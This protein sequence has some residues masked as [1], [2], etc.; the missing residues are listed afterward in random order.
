MIRPNENPLAMG[1]I[2]SW[3]PEVRWVRRRDLRDADD[4]VAEEGIHSSSPS[5]PSSKL[6]ESVSLPD[7]SY[8]SL[9]SELNR[10]KEQLMPAATACAD[11]INTY[12]QSSNSTNPRYEFRKARSSCNP[13]ESLG[14]ATSKSNLN[15]YKKKSRKRKWHQQPTPQGLSQFVNRSAIKL[16]NIDALLGFII[17]NAV[18]GEDETFVFVDLCGAPGGFSEYILYRYFH[19]AISQTNDPEMDDAHC[20]RING[21]RSCFGFGMSLNGSNSDGEG[22]HWDLDH[23]KRY[24]INCHDTPTAMKEGMRSQLS[25]H[26]CDGADGSGSIY[27]WDNVVQLQHDIRVKI[28]PTSCDNPLVNLVVAD[29]GFDAQRD[30]TDQESI[31]FKIIVSQTA[32]AL[33]LLRPGGTFVLKMFGFR[34]DATRHMLNVLHTYFDQ[35]TFVKPVLSRPASAERYLV[36]R[37]FVGTGKEWD[38]LAWRKKMLQ[39]SHERSVQKQKYPPLEDLMASFD[40]DMAQLNIDT[41]RSIVNRLDEKRKCAEQGKDVN[42]FEEHRSCLDTKA[43]ESAWQLK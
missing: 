42:A 12:Y 7:K 36:C 14:A 3:F 18:Q 17:T 1:I 30:S 26:V 40:L 9:V 22:A 4:F 43:Y 8:D 32:A 28:D 34:E 27:N 37:G 39:T 6:A 41:C 25:Y 16:A 11:A 19:P 2:S 35:M 20:L 31:A 24:H 13:Y 29:G 21:R 38:G 33:T 5:L 23:L 15:Q 10:I